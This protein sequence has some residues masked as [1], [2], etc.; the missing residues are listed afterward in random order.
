[1]HVIQEC[2]FVWLCSWLVGTNHSLA[3]PGGSIE[4]SKLSVPCLNWSISSVGKVETL[5]E[6]ARELSSFVLRCSWDNA[7]VVLAPCSS[8][9]SISGAARLTFYFP[10]TT[11]NLG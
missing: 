10:V 3:V 1:M 11:G 2:N 6:S 8:P 7:L 5:A 9:S 4:M